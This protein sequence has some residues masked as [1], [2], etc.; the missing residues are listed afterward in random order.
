MGWSTLVSYPDLP[1]PSGCKF[2]QL[3]GMNDPRASI[4]INVSNDRVQA[5]VRT[6]IFQ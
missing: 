6:G 1:R 2:L 3:R 4:G 5:S